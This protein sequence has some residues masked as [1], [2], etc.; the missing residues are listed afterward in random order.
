MSTELNIHQIMY[1]PH[2]IIYSIYRLQPKYSTIHT[3]LQVQQTEEIDDL[4]VKLNLKDK[5]IAKLKEDKN[6]LLKHLSESKDA[7]IKQADKV[8]LY[9]TYV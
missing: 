8:A 5:E 6:L 1:V 7:V 9:Y 3:Y 2:I 4:N